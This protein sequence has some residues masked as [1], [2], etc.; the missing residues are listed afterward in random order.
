MPDSIQRAAAITVH[1][2]SMTLFGIMIIFGIKFSY[3][4]RS[5]ISP[6]LYLPKW[7]IYT[8]IPVS[9]LIL[10]LHGLSFLLNELKGKSRDN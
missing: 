3:F 4:V 7:I 10:M 1:F 8:I 9:G 5:Q 6:A 2:V